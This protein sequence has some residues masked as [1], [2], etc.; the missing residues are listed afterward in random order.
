MTNNLKF[1][2]LFIAAVILVC[3]Y[4]IIGIPKSKQEL[5]DNWQHNIRL[6]LDLKGGSH[7]VLQV[8]LQ[9]A[10]KA[11]ADSVI[12]RMKDV[13]AKA[14]VPAGDINRNDPNSLTTADTIQINV[15]GVAATKAGDFRTAIQENFGGVWNLTTVNSTDYRLNMKPTEALKLKQDALTQTINTIEKKI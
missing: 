12:Q 5:L 11:E 13:L 7:L 6:C 9:D 15:A 3:I 1:K 8:Q 14:N 2:A 4:G 10:F